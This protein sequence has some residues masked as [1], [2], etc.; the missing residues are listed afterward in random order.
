MV[1]IHDKSVSDRVTNQFIIWVK[2]C[3]QMSGSTSST[4][5]GKFLTR[6]LRRTFSYVLQEILEFY[7]TFLLFKKFKCFQVKSK[8]SCTC[9]DW[10]LRPYS[11]KYAEIQYV[12]SFKFGSHRD[13]FILG[14]CCQDKSILRWKCVIWKFREKSNTPVSKW[15]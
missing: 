5:T 10:S 15:A 3:W 11:Q 1:T 12:G 14:F 2:Q 8:L 9:W 4:T 13:L 7:I 6:Y